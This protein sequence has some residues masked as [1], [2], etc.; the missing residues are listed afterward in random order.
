MLIICYISNATAK[1]WEFIL[2]IVNLPA[3]RVKQIRQTHGKYPKFE[4]L[5]FQENTRIIS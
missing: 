5:G 4:P 3:S 1:I 2:R